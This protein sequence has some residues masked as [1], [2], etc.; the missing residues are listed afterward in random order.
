MRSLYN[1]FEVFTNMAQLGMVLGASQ[2]YFL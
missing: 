1:K 2:F